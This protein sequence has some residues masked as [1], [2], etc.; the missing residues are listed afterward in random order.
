M[1]IILYL[2]LFDYCNCKKKER[3]KKQPKSTKIVHDYVCATLTIRI[4]DGQNVVKMVWHCKEEWASASDVCQ[5][6]I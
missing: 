1:N 4:T 6:K 2:R 3:K 5:S